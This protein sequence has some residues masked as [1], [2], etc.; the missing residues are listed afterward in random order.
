MLLLAALVVA[1]P[2]NVPLSCSVTRFEGNTWR[3]VSVERF[4]GTEAFGVII[5]KNGRRVLAD[6]GG[7]DYQARFL[8]WPYPGKLLAVSEHSGAGHYM[9]TTMYLC[10]KG[11]LI[12]LGWLI[13]GESGGPVFRDLDGDGR[14]EILLDNWSHYDGRK[15]TAWEVLK[16]EPGAKIV[17][18]KTLPK[19]QKLPRKLPFLTE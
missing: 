2:A 3:I 14:K 13:D 17:S 16:V 15:V 6:T 1:N 8:D 10:H 18:W 19:T 11:R 7:G 9:M 12:D 4:D 5:S